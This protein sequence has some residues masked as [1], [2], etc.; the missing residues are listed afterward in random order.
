MYLWR[1]TSDACSA[2]FFHRVK[3]IQRCDLEHDRTSAVTL[4]IDMSHEPITPTPSFPFSQ[5]SSLVAIAS[6]SAIAAIF[7]TYLTYPFL[8]TADGILRWRLATQ[9]LANERLR[10]VYLLPPLGSLLMAGIY[11]LSGSYAL[12]TLLQSFVMLMSGCWLILVLCPKQLSPLVYSVPIALFIALPT[13]SV[14][15]VIL[16]DSSLTFAGMAI[17]LCLLLP[18]DECQGWRPSLRFKAMSLLPVFVILFGMRHNSLTVLPVVCFLLWRYS[19]SLKWRL[20][21]F[22]MLALSILLVKFVVP[23]EY[24][25]PRAPA[26]L[27]M[28]WDLVGLLVDT[29]D[30]VLEES[31]SRL[32][33]TSQMRQRFYSRHSNELIWDAGAPLPARRI[34]QLRISSKIKTIY[35][36]T[37]YRMPFQLMRYK[38]RQWGLTL[39]VTQP[40]LE[41]ARGIHE[42]ERTQVPFGA[43][44]NNRDNVIL[45]SF[46]DTTQSL[47]FMALRPAIGFLISGLVVGMLW[48]SKSVYLERFAVV[49]VMSLTY[50]G[51][52]LI[53]TQAMEFRYYAPSFFL[54]LILILAGILQVLTPLLRRDASPQ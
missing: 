26:A 32:G 7:L 46:T 22:S 2:T 47:G 36:E 35:L 41:A 3:F 13:V 40:L 38:I 5:V 17:L 9:L 29:N 28:A 14:F 21:A 54:T 23:A 50:Y 1:R 16:T 49:Y 18:T 44:V 45:N 33:D 37:I 30:P 27:G 15:S 6:L 19:A 20:S 42:S 11:R 8:T 43:R 53:Q 52:F 12:Y 39:G 24:S 4:V 48:L 31:L 25:Q 10:E 34:S 51:A